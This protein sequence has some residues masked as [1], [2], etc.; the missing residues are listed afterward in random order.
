MDPADIGEVTHIA[1]LRQVKWH[2]LTEQRSS[3]MHLL[4]LVSLLGVRIMVV[5]KANWESGGKMDKEE[6]QRMHCNGV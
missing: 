4:A 1:R 2:D 3:F 5:C 6:V